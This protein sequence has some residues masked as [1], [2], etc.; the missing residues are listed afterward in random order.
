MLL[1]YVRANVGQTS[2]NVMAIVIENQH[3]HLVT[4]LEP[5]ARWP[6]LEPAALWPAESRIIEFSST[7]VIDI[8]RPCLK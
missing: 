2:V 1:D 6:V 7:L 8:P 5:A 3:T 4:A